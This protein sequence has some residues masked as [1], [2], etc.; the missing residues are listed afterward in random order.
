MFHHAHNN[1][2][3]SYEKYR[4]SPLQQED[5]AQHYEETGGHQKSFRLCMYKCVLK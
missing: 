5:A 1:D 2:M 3:V 4:A